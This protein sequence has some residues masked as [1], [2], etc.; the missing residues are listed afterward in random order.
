MYSWKHWFVFELVVSPIAGNSVLFLLTPFIAESGA[1]CETYVLT[2]TDVAQTSNDGS[3]KVFTSSDTDVCAMWNKETENV[4]KLP[5]PKRIGNERLTM[6]KL[7]NMTKR[8][9]EEE[10]RKENRETLQRNLINC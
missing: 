3:L 4:F 6:T 9:R 7:I 8:Q 10:E 5:S 2:M 1:T